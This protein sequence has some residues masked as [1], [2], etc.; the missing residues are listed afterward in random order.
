MSLLSELWNCSLLVTLELFL[1]AI[2]CLSSL[3]SL[4]GTAQTS[5]GSRTVASGSVGGGNFKASNKM[6][7]WKLPIV[8]DSAGTEARVCIQGIQG[9]SPQTSFAPPQKVKYSSWLASPSYTHTPWLWPNGSSGMSS[10]ASPFLSGL[11]GLSCPD[12]GI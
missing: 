10:D 11:R 4:P 2:A 7:G 5:L 3:L 12:L 9:D 1:K 8:K 6:P